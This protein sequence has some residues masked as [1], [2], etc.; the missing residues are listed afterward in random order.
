MKKN[1]VFILTM[2]LVSAVLLAFKSNNVLN[3]NIRNQDD[4]LEEKKKELNNSSADSLIYKGKNFAFTKKGKISLGAGFQNDFYTNENKEGYFYTEVIADQFVNENNKRLPLN[5]S[6]VIDRSGSMN[7]SKINYVKEAAKFVVDNLTKDDILSIVIYDDEVEVLQKAIKVENK[8]LIKNKINSII[9]R[10]ST[11][12]TGGMLK[13]YAEVKSNFSKGYVNRVL[14]LSDGLANIGITD[15]AEI[16]KIVSIKNKE[17]GISL[18][19]FG[20]GNDYNEDLMT[21]M[22][23]TGT[24]NYYFIDSP[25]KIP[26]IFEK[27][28]KGLMT[29]VAQNVMLSIKLPENIEL[30]KVYGYK[31]EKVGNTLEINFRDV[32]SEEIKGVLLKYKIK[33]NINQPINIFSL[34]NYDD[35]TTYNNEKLNIEIS[36]Q[37]TDNI[38]LYKERNVEKVQQQIILFEANESLENAMRELDKGNFD[39]AKKIMQQNK[40]YLNLNKSLVDK[41]AELQKLNDVNINYDNRIQNAENMNADEI[42][43]MQKS[44]KSQSY[45]IKNKK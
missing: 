31:Y 22:A 24:G 42:K 17:D 11:N 29:V 15:S 19:T 18:S 6:L 8:Q 40:T 44:S 30:L 45:Q 14:L 32:F 26:S 23:E 13:G 16:N 28:L 35:A 20:V 33:N 2:I 41:S 21:S 5:I 43:F 12:L 37:F 3:S 4:G 25:D 27:E 7:G 34:V 9:D 1:T 38:K 39:E 10:G 36:Q